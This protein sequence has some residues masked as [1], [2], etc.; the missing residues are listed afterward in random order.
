M[1]GQKVTQNVADSYSIVCSVSD[2]RQR[3]VR[4]ASSPDS[5]IEHR[6]GYCSGC[7]QIR[8]TPENMSNY[9]RKSLFLSEVKVFCQEATI[10][11]LKNIIRPSATK[12]RPVIWSMLLF[13]GIVGTVY[14]CEQRI[15]YYL[16]WPTSV[17]VQVEY[18]DSMR[19]PMTTFCNENKA[20]R[21]FAEAYG[22]SL[23]KQ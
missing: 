9:T 19:F 15:Q 22:K 17:D 11:G 2:D 13:G 8:N 7:G 3:I 1:Y 21:R 20:S 6:V 14:L 10:A 4:R 18:V 16:T 23:Q 12:I 5:C